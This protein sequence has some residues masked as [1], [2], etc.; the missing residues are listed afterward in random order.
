MFISAPTLDDLLRRVLSKLLASTSY[1]TPT[2]GAT[3]EMTCVLLQISNPRARLSRTEMK[4]TLF[5]CLGECLWYLASAND[6]KFI[7]YYLKNYKKYSDDGL[8]LHGAYGPRL[9][10]MR[11]H[12]QVA[13]IIALLKKKP[14]SRQAVIQ[15]FDA[16]DIAK[17]HKD[18][19]CTCTLQFMVRDG[20]LLMFTN[21]RSNDAFIGLPHDIFAFTM[22]QEIVARALKLELGTY[23]HAVGS[24]HL[25]KIN[26]DAAR[27]YLREGWQSTVVMPLMPKGK[28]WA[29]IQKLLL[30]ER[31]IRG[32]RSVNVAALRLDRYWA[33]LVRLLQ[34]YSHFKRRDSERIGQIKKAI[35]VRL[36]D[37]YIDD[38]KQSAEK[39]KAKGAAV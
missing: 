32:G 38:K 21:M 28:P 24:L 36:Y 8:T 34:I 18:V 19:P 10:N 3:T 6:L 5:S 37:P 33:D 25:Y 4:G 1:V 22:I 13:N 9:F 20:R 12:D 2:K 15:L 7:G 30:A 29:S 26:R 31:T 39:Q 35:T 14:A 17:K 11:H 23:S 27:R 16:K